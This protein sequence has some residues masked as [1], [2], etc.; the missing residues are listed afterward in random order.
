[1]SEFPMCDKL[2]S[3]SSDV[4]TLIEFFEWVT[5][6]GWLLCE[7]EDTGKICMDEPV[8]EYF[9]LRRQFQ[10]L[11]YEFLEID[12]NQLETERRAILDSL[13]RNLE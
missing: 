1:M 10:S 13:S 5:N 3:V 6:H 2:N 11:V 4:S 9:P 12:E 7:L 8:F